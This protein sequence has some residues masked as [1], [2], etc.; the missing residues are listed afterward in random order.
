MVAKLFGGEILK[1]PWNRQTDLYYNR[2]NGSVFDLTDAQ[3]DHPIHYEDTVSFIEEAS[4][5]FTGSEYD[6]LKKALLLK[7]EKLD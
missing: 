3:F 5:G 7:L 4:Q 1:T 6:S 2:I